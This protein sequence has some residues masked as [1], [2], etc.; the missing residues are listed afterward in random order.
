MS[1]HTISA[2]STSVLPHSAA[3][4]QPLQLLAVLSS[5]PCPIKD[6]ILFR[7]KLLC[8]FTPE[9]HGHSPTRQEDGLTYPVPRQSLSSAGNGRALLRAQ[10]PAPS[11][12][13]LLATPEQK[14]LVAQHLLSSSEVRAHPNGVPCPSGTAVENDGGAVGW[15]VPVSWGETVKQRLF[16]RGSW[17]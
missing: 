10:S 14:P 13:R 2:S 8:L 5:R 16:S 9:K 3:G 4:G 17:K 15:L 6:F 12:G 7:E 11:Q 1:P